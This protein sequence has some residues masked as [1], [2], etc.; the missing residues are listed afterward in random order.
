MRFRNVDT[1]P[2][3]AGCRRRRRR[4]LVILVWVPEEWQTKG[5]IKD[6]NASQSDPSKKSLQ[7]LSGSNVSIEAPNWCSSD[8]SGAARE[9][10]LVFDQAPIK[11]AFC[12]HPERR[13]FVARLYAPAMSKAFL[14]D[15]ALENR[16]LHSPISLHGQTPSTMNRYASVV[17]NMALAAMLLWHAQTPHRASLV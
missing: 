3:F 2:S 8:S 7:G 10:G 13:E 1:S 17:V 6:A 14:T 4:T 5:S 11:I 16:V 15:A 9:P 12:W